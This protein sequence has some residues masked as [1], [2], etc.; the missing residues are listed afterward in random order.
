MILLISKKKNIEAL[1][2]EPGDEDYNFLLA[3]VIDSKA[4]FIITG[5]KDLT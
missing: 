4:T 2:L 1:I 5:D 3:L